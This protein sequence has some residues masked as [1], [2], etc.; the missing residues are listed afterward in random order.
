M[1]C[2]AGLVGPAIGRG[3]A[4]RL[5]GLWRAASAVTARQTVTTVGVSGAGLAPA[6]HAREARRAFGSG[7]TA[8]RRRPLD[9]AVV[10]AAP[11]ST[12]AAVTALPFDAAPLTADRPRSARGRGG[13]GR[14]GPARTAPIT[15]RLTGAALG[16]RGTRPAA[17]RTTDLPFF[18]PRAAGERQRGTLPSAPCR[19][20][21]QQAQLNGRRANAPGRAARECSCR[22]PGRSSLTGVW[23]EDPH[24]E[25]A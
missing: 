3:A 2:T 11:L 8:R 20:Q 1:T 5:T 25:F 16:A 22:G 4:R 15:A 10:F 23:H 19:E 21:H 12:V 14:A 9:A 13:T 7:L 18:A 6:A 17:R 24:E